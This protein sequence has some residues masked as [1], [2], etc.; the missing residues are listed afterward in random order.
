[1][2]SFK[3]GAGMRQG[4][5]QEMMDGLN[6]V[7]S[8]LSRLDTDALPEQMRQRL[9]EIRVRLQRA[10]NMVEELKK[11]DGPPASDQR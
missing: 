4:E 6:E 5:L 3:E 7:E 1:M 2:A 10:Q 11:E 8:G 9:H